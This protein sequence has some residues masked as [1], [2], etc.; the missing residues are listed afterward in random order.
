MSVKWCE[1][2]VNPESFSSTHSILA[3]AVVVVV[4]SHVLAA[5]LVAVVAA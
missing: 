1:L 3:A 4:A 2:L 5:W